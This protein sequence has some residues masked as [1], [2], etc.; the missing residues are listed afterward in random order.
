[1]AERNGA[2]TVFE[3]ARATKQRKEQ[4]PELAGNCAG[5]RGR[6][7]GRAKDNERQR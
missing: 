4:M 3:P 1:M 6:R 7:R 2:V 5:S